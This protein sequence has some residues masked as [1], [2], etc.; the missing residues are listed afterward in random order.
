MCKWR[1]DR[2]IGL[3]ASPAGACGL[4]ASA[5]QVTMW[6]TAKTRH[7]CML[8][9]RMRLHAGSARCAIHGPTDMGR[10]VR[11]DVSTLRHR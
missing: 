2:Y 3:V 5:K 9:G 7:P 1:M 4:T 6:A 11:Y 10:K 8:G